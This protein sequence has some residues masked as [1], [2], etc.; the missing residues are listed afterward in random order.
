MTKTSRAAAF[1]ENMKQ[2]QAEI[3]SSSI[4]Q[5]TGRDSSKPVAGTAQGL[6]AYRR[7]F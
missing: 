3:V 2:E 1:L 6:K 7:L 4:N 5:K